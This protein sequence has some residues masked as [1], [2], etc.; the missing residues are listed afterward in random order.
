MW[1]RPAPGLRDRCTL[2]NPRESSKTRD[3][4]MLL[5]WRQPKPDMPQRQSD[6]RRSQSTIGPCSVGRDGS[7]LLCG[8]PGRPGVMK[9]I[10]RL[11]VRMAKSI[12]HH[13]GGGRLQNSAGAIGAVHSI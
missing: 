8:R 1:A 9:T 2:V 6:A 3:G 7:S 5:L 11:A 12:S 4:V 10:E 13:Y